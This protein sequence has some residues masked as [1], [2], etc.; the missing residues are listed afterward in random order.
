M[1]IRVLGCY[2][3]ELSDCNTTGF[4][5]NRSVLLDAGTICT[6]LNLSEQRKIRYV[7]LS[8]IHM[9]HTKGLTSLSENLFAEKK[10]ETV[11]IIST[12]EI[13]KELKEHFFND[14][15]WPDFTKIPNRRKPLFRLKTIREGE[16]I[17][18][19][20]LRVR[21][22]RV[23]H[24]VPSVGFLIREKNGSLLFSGDTYRTDRIWK[25]ASQDPCLKAAMI[26]V[27]FPNALEKLAEA[28]KHLTPDLLFQEFLKIKKPH[29][30]LYIYHVKPRYLSRITRELTR[31]QIKGLTLLK[32]G[33]VFEI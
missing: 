17:E 25:A 1:K 33:L 8:H 24:I 21:A 11:I 12:R 23:N 31:L 6:A 27:S 3:A 2:G 10:W 4:L 5:I 19:D 16:T 26:E 9:D 13:L 15:I 30:P 20:G 18:I 7:L 29:L 32:D 22:F 28:S 14:R